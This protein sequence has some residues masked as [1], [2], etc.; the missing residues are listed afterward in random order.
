MYCMSNIYSRGKFNSQNI[1]K[2]NVNYIDFF[3]SNINSCFFKKHLFVSIPFL[4]KVRNFLLI[5]LLLTKRES[6]CYFKQWVFFFTIHTTEWAQSQREV[7]EWDSTRISERDSEK[8]SAC[9]C[10]GLAGWVF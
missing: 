2:P 7:E 9:S 8:L 6:H 5:I 10:C 3:S 4:S 1:M